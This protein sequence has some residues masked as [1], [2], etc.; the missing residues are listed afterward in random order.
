M[1]MGRSPLGLGPSRFEPASHFIA[2]AIKYEEAV[3]GRVGVPVS[4]LGK[5][6]LARLDDFVQVLEDT[7]LDFNWLSFMPVNNPFNAK[8]SCLSSPHLASQAR[9]RRLFLPVGQD[10]RRAAQ[11]RRARLAVGRLPASD[12]RK[13]IFQRTLARVWS[14]VSSV[15]RHVTFGTT[16]VCVAV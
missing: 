8:H 1:G 14:S 4:H 5:P 12:G 13:P 16:W 15:S 2:G 7:I 9:L 6:R 3:G 11:S 10:G